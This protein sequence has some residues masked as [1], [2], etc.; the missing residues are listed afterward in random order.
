MRG[1]TITKGYFVNKKLTDEVFDEEGWVHTGDVGL[2]EPNGTLRI[3][4]RIK[5][6]F[7]LAQVLL[8]MSK[9]YLGRVYCSRKIREYLLKK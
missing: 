5:N 2:I 1:S 3:I 4:D 8:N 6:I 9:Y 7:K